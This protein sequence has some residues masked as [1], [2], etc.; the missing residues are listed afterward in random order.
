MLNGEEIDT[1]EEANPLIEVENHISDDYV[2]EESIKIEI[3]QLINKI[4]DEKT[5][6]EVRNELIDRFGIVT[7]EMEIYM[8]E[9]WFEKLA[10]SLNINRVRQT[11]TLLEIE[12]S[13]DVSNNIQG[14]KLFLIAYNI[15]PRFKFNYRMRRIYIT[16]PLINL[17]SHFIYYVVSLLNE[18]INMVKKM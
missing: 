2:S 7:D 6:E 8:Y 10:S 16:L 4:E 9:E 14:D 15:N 18:I 5:L 3:H 11:E 1:E 12:L 17:E 13:E